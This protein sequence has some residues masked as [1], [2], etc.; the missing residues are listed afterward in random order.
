MLIIKKPNKIV[1]P[2][3][4]FKDVVRWFCIVHV[5]CI[6]VGLGF[7]VFG[8]FENTDNYVGIFFVVIAS[9]FFS[10]CYIGLFVYSRFSKS[11]QNI[12]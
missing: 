8:D 11:S 7:Q 9:F 5:L 3:I 2:R 6:L 12:D 10:I 4:K 1:E